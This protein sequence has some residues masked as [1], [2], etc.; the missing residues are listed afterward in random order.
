MDA[1]EKA[2]LD[3]LVQIVK[4]QRRLEALAFEAESQQKTQD[5][6]ETNFRSC[7][8]PQF[9]LAKNGK[10]LRKPLMRRRKP[11]GMGFFAGEKWGGLKCFRKV[12]NGDFFGS[13]FNLEKLFLTGFRLPKTA[14]SAI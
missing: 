9:V 8:N 11:P 5:D 12:K 13:V 14:Q 1:R 6:L 10:F 3:L 7:E 2:L 4:K